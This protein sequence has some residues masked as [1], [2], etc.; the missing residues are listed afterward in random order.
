M[1][2]TSAGNLSK[3]PC[4]DRD[5]RRVVTVLAGHG[6]WALRLQLRLFVTVNFPEVDSIRSGALSPDTVGTKVCAVHP[7]CHT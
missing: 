4:V 7:W 6:R 2:K 3:N 5:R 1:S